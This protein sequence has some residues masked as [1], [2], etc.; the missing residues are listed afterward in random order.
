MSEADAGIEQAQDAR[1]RLGV[2]SLLKPSPQ[3]DQPEAWS[4]NFCHRSMAEYFVAR[5]LV[6]ALRHGHPAAGD[7]LS[8]VILGPEITDFAAL[9]LNKDDRVADMTRTLATLARSAGLGADHGYLGGNA[10]TLAYRGRR[11]TCQPP[12]GRSGS[13]LRGPVWS[14]PVRGRLRR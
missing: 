14:G 10:I 13:Q 4:V 9:S 5:A 7:L 8:S 12:V 6:R 11:K 1:A 2:R 3:A